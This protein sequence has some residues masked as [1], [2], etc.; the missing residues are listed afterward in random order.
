MASL[1][2]LRSA[3]PAFAAAASAVM[4]ATAHA[5]ET[6]G[7]YAP[8]TLCLRQ[9]E[10]YWGALAAAILGMAA[11]ALKRPLAREGLAL[12][13]AAIFLAGAVVASYHAGVEW[14]WWSGPATCSGAGGAV[15]ADALSG[16]LSGAKVR[17]PACD[18]A[19][20]RLLGISMAGYNAAI[21]A[22]LAVMGFV[23]AYGRASQ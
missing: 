1:S 5:F 10:V 9:R 17:P 14:K 7:G 12:C 8:C 19:A 13:L 16:L 21:S 15:G 20:W 2:S 4:L 6:F 18:Q 3:W 22:G 23:A 11:I